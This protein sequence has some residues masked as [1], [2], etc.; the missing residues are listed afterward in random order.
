MDNRKKGN[1]AERITKNTI[2]RVYIDVLKELNFDKENISD[3]AE[4]LRRLK[5]RIESKQEG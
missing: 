1:K 4:L 3:E 2:L 5:R